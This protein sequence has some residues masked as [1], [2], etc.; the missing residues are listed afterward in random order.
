MP[1]LRVAAFHVCHGC[2][3]TTVAVTL[4]RCEYVDTAAVVVFGRADWRPDS[5]K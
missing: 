3:I 2:S 4:S 1:A 5:W